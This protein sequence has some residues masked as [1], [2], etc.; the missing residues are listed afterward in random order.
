M[1]ITTYFQMAPGATPHLKSNGESRFR[2][3]EGGIVSKRQYI[4]GTV[5]TGDSI[6][7][8]MTLSFHAL[9]FTFGWTDRFPQV[10]TTLAITLE[11]RM[12]HS[13]LSKCT[14]SNLLHVNRA[15]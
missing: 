8:R 13:T 14:C 10:S 5:W 15:L 4:H 7:E 1:S 12:Q 6:G 9:L 11:P 3:D 2:H